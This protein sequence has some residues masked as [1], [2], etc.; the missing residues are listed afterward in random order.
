MN[1]AIRRSALIFM[2]AFA[3]LG[4]DSLDAADPYKPSVAFERRYAATAY[5]TVF[6]VPIFSRSG[7]GFGFASSE[8]LAP[9]EACALNLRF[10]SGSDPA[11]AHGLNRFGF[12]QEQ[13]NQCGSAKESSY[14]GLM[15]ASAEESLQDAKKALNSK[16]QGD[17]TFVAAQ[18]VVKQDTAHY[19]VRHLLLPASY[20]TS[21]VAQLTRR[22]QTEFASPKPAEP[23]KTLKLGQGE[24]ATF[25]W[26]VWEAMRS[27]GK[28]FAESFTY[29]GKTFQL[30]MEKHADPKAGAEL[31]RSGLAS[32][33]SEIVVLNCVL[34]GQNGQASTFRVWFDNNNPNLLPLRFEFRPKSYLRLVY[35]AT[36]P[37]TVNPVRQAALSRS[38]AE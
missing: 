23:E 15:T 38:I 3:V 22:L 17:V 28:T 25:L 29:N 30:K 31:E 36:V 20:G 26:S 35:E 21:N 34:K 16:Q 4:V 37:K 19:S 2:F 27:E 12:I 6:S 9:G 18:G 11:R 32:S 1:L 14:L 5:I 33:A 7:V 8:Q 24:N 13:V 10:L